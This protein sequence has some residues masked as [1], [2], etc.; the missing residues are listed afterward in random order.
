MRDPP[1][2]APRKWE[3]VRK[4]EPIMTWQHGRINLARYYVRNSTQKHLH[5]Q[6]LVRTGRFF[7]AGGKEITGRGYCPALVRFDADK[8]CKTGKVLVKL[9]KIRRITFGILHASQS[10]ALDC[11]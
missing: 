3:A 4:G 2:A 7:E 10:V 8:C 6:V 1:L 11:A 9:F 5:C